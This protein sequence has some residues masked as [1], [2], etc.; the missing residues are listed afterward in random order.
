MANRRNIV[1]CANDVTQIGGISRVIHSSAD[2]F[3]RRGYDVSLLGMNSIGDERSYID[4]SDQSSKYRTIVPY[5]ANPPSRKQNFEKWNRMRGEAVG[6]MRA[7]LDSIDIT[8][9]IFII[10]HVYVMEHLVETGV[11]IGG[12]DG[13]AVMGMYHN[14]FDSCKLVGDLP[15]VQRTYSQA[16]RF[17][18]LTEVDR[19]RY[20]SAGMSNASY[21]YNPVELI[22]SPERVDWLA[23]EK[24][25]VYVGRFAKEK[26]IPWMIRIWASV[27]ELYP[28]WSF[29][30]Y[31]VGPEED[32]IALEILR[33][34]VSR[35]VQVMGSTQNPE[36]VFASSRIMLMASD[37]EG[38]PVAVV[39]AGLC[40]L[41]TLTV[42]CCPGMSIL[43]DDG[44]SGYV[45]PVGD[46]D[47]FRSRLVEMMDDV[48]LNESLGLAAMQHMARFDPDRIVDDW[49]ELF[50]FSGL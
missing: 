42:D 24:K 29:E 15:R 20:A 34:G 4:D 18:A 14:S 9:T 49:E 44:V 50:A 28:D 47:A 40:G 2:A 23:R 6:Y 3:S 46:V 31:G 45:T 32:D 39:E 43:V 11:E 21:I 19:D 8:D 22:S 36:G 48:Q 1:I 17:L 27:A 25:I 5:T 33:S 13:L 12:E 30:I 10:L 38:L 26:N 37:Y 35:S 16:T 7:Y 41:P